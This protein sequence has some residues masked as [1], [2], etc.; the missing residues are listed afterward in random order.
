[1]FLNKSKH[2]FNKQYKLY[3]GELS[4]KWITYIN[5]NSLD[6]EDKLIRLQQYL[7]YKIEW[8]KYIQNRIKYLGLDFNF[9]TL[10]DEY[11]NNYFQQI[12]P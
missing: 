10:H 7:N 9:K 3:K 12:L 2:Q 1:M 6:T 4:E 5:C 11:E 8:N